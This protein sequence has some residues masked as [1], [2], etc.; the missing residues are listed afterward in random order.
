VT[1]V[2]DGTV[3]VTN[4]F[5]VYVTEV[6]VAPVFAGTPTNMVVAVGAT[7]MVTNAATDDD[8][9]TNGLSYALLNAPTNAAVDSG[10][11][12]TWT[13]V[14]AQAPSTNVIMTVVTDSG[15]PAL[16]ATNSFTVVVTNV[17]T[18]FVITS[19]ITSNEVATVTWNSVSNETY[20]LQYKDS[21]TDT[22]WTD[23][24]P[25]VQA[26][27]S[28]ASMTNFVG[29]TPQRFYRVK[30]GEAT[31]SGPTPPVI[32]SLELSNG[33]AVVKWSS[34]D[35]ATYRLQYKTDLMA[36]TWQD[37]T[38]DVVATG[39]L[40]AVT[41]MVGSDPQRFYRIKGMW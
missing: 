27:G 25:S 38:P 23:V 18:L 35:G 30:Q 11:V 9:P 28:S 13:P 39:P 2:S 24:L 19:I 6:N 37:V 31:P 22:N 29:A 34:V 7:L 8:L 32:Q 4:S 36:V 10:G 33:V 1:V 14:G 40:T 15:S 12:I 21:L 41:N 5:T 17:Q 20:V 26:T 3:A 16:S